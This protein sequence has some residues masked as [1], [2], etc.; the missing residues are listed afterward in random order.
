[1][2]RQLKQAYGLSRFGALLRTTLLVTFAFVA[3]ALFFVVIAAVEI[4]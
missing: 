3:A 2:Y 1:M 4:V